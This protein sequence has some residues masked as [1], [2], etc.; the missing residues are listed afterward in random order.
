MESVHVLKIVLSFGTIGFFAV[1]AFL[2]ARA[3]EQLKN[4]PN[5]KRSSLCVTQRQGSEIESA[6]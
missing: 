5:H 3:T 1:F 4:D 2:S 6:T